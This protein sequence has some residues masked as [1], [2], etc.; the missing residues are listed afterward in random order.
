M[1]SDS[2]D[3]LNDEMEE[4]KNKTKINSK[5]DN[6]NVFDLKLNEIF[7]VQTRNDISSKR[8]NRKQ[9]KNKLKSLNKTKNKRAKPESRSDEKPTTVTLANVI[10]GQDIRQ[11]VKYKN[12]RVL[13]DSGA[14]ESLIDGG[15]C[16]N[17][18]SKRKKFKTANGTKTTDCEAM[19]H[20]CLPEFSETKVIHCTA[21]K[22]EQLL[23]LGLGN[24]PKKTLHT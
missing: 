23:A 12:L 13:L 9:S 21:G 11:G 10:N 7:T 14:S 1:E 18:T 22:S 3:D 6:L 2:E 4:D 17:K 20:F 15:Y 5:F 8:L 16:E 19:V 24:E